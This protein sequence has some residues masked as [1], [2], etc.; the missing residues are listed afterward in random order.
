MVAFSRQTFIELLKNELSKIG[1]YLDIKFFDNW[2]EHD[3]AIKSD[4]SQMFLDSYDSD[5]LGDAHYF[6]YSLF[7][8]KSPINS[9]HYE[10][11]QVDMWLDRACSEGD[12][13]ARYLLYQKVV[14]K[15]LKDIPAVFLYHIKPHYAYNRHKIRKFVA[16]P[17]QNIQFHRIM[18]YE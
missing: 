11:S 8:S 5:I 2:E 14:E 10:D 18:L 1:I 6:L 4:S 3:R 7:H 17:Y 16:D 9:L 12:D 13:N 15:I